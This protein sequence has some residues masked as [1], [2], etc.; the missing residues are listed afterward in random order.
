MIR[1]EAA[2]ESVRH[3]GRGPQSPARFSGENEGPSLVGFVAG[4][5]QG[6]LFRPLKAHRDARGWLVEL[7]RH[8]EM[9]EGLWPVM[10]YASMTL[11]GVTRGPHEHADQTDGF[12][13]IGPSDF[14][15]WL[16]DTRPESPTFGHTA[17]WDVGESNPAAIW[18]PP[19]VVHAYRNT[20]DVPGLVFNAPNRLYAGW[21]KRDAVDEVRHED[22]EDDRFPMA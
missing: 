4:E 3:P 17:T 1:T 19:G 20:G 21:G 15:V 2:R 13:F 6:A 14:R 11:P 12:A 18:V 9:S 8:D 22:A 16:W 5:I 7:F 10:A